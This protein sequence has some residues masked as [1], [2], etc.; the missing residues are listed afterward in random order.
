[1]TTTST[2]R[3]DI[4]VVGESLIDITLNADGNC[5]ERVGGNPAALARSLG[6]LGIVTTLLTTFGADP[7]G[8]TINHELTRCGVRIVQAGHRATRTSTVTAHPDRPGA[9]TVDLC[10]ELV[11]TDVPSCGHLHVGS[12]AV[13]RAPGA[14]DVARLVSRQTPDTTISYDVN[15]RPSAMGPRH[16]SIA[17]IDEMISR[18]DVVKLSDADLAWLRPGERHGDAIRWLMSRGPA[19]VVVTH[20]SAGATG[21]TRSGSVRVRGHR[22]DVAHGDEIVGRNRR[23]SWF[24]RDRPKDCEFV[25]CLVNVTTRSRGLQQDRTAV[26]RPARPRTGAYSNVSKGVTLCSERRRRDDRAGS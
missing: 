4:A 25:H 5:R 15:V 21:Y 12:I 24:P 8:R 16:I 7:H 14:D 10:W 2:A 1:M 23:P 18:S 17:R 19:I 6:R 13:V 11:H 3:R 22:V 20:G 26:V 9:P